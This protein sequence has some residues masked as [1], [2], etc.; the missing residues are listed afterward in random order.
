MHGLLHKLAL[1]LVLLHILGGCCY[2]HA[3]AATPDCCREGH[4]D[5]ADHHAPAHQ[6]PAHHGRGE[7][8][9]PTDGRAPEREGC[10]ESQCVFVV[11]ETGRAARL[12][13]PLCAEA[14]LSAPPAVIPD[15][16]PIAAR[17]RPPS[18]FGEP[19]GRLHLIFQVL[20][21]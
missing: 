15:G 9:C 5:E 14:A 10:D 6:E 2:H 18:T 20:L 13:G 19:P 11:P 12:L 21:M 7:P 8:C 16:S 4:H 3:H 1:G 17:S